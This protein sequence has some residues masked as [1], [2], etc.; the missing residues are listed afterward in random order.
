LRD[1]SLLALGVCDLKL[2]DRLPDRRFLIGRVHAAQQR[3]RRAPVSCRS[4]QAMT[5]ADFLPVSKDVAAVS[6]ESNGLDPSMPEHI[7]IYDVALGGHPHN[8]W[9]FSAIALPGKRPVSSSPHF[10]RPPFAPKRVAECRPELI[11]SIF[12]ASDQAAAERSKTRV[13]CREG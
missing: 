5:G 10:G 8:C 3:G 1:Q 13:I 11:S 6:P 7:I 12:A 4:S 2:V 9:Y